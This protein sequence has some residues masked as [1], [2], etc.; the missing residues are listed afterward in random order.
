MVQMPVDFSYAPGGADDLLKVRDV[1][2]RLGVSTAI[3]YKLCDRGEL[4]H[5]RVS[6]AIR[7]AP[8]DLAEFIDRTHRPSFR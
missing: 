6:N 2:V 5:V 8:A 3:V 4:S 1:A 7:I